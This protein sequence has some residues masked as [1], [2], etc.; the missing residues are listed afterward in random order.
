MKRRRKTCCRKKS[1]CRFKGICLG[2]TVLALL[3]AAPLWAGWEE[4]RQ[5][6]TLS[7]SLRTRYELWN[8]FDPGNIPSSQNENNDYGFG[9]T[10][11]RLG[12][13]YDTKKWFDAFAEVQNTAL[14]N[15]PD[16]ANAPAPP[17]RAR[18]GRYL[19]RPPS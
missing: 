14:L 10:L 17:G 11:L 18:I 2:L 6:L 7:A 1:A 13:R 8:W 9:A 15:L 16:D 5:R 19:F 4:Q 3:V 12:L